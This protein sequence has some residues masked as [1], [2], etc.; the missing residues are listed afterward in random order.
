MP[1]ISIL[2]PVYN[3]EKYLKQCIDSLINQTFKDIEI[4][5]L[6]DGST[7]SSSNIC[8]DYAAIDSRIRVVHKK[9]SRYGHTMNVG[10]EHAIGDYI[11]I[12]ESDDF[13]ELTMFENLYNV[14]INDD[15]DIVKS[16]FYFYFSINNHN[17]I[18]LN[19]NNCPTDKVIN[20]NSN[21]ELLELAPAIWS[22]LYKKDFLNKNDIWFNETPGASYQD[23]SF[24][25]K[26]LSKAQKV[27]LKPEAY[28]HYRQDNENS[29]IKSFKKVNAIFDE[30]EEIKKF[31]KIYAQYE[32]FYQNIFIKQ[33]NDYVCNFLRV[34]SEYKQTF[35]DRFQ[36]DFKVL[37]DKKLLKK[38]FFLNIKKYELKMLLKN[39]NKFMKLKLSSH[40]KVTFLQKIFSVKNEDN[41]KVLRLLGFKIKL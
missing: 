21:P 7:D 29:S 13:A 12:V 40:K 10:L 19:T 9:N 24:S 34:G 41:K 36:N 5:L 30:Y 16:N 1:K 25:T 23:V 18:F 35:L 20:S 33:Y 14:A 2:V 27:I 28:I 6:D 22:A 26:V 11:G 4:L 32:N 15:A 17:E 37:Y 31:F 39:K 38:E 3:V 8:D